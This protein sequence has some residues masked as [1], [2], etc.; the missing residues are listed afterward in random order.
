LFLCFHP[1]FLSVAAYSGIRCCMPLRTRPPFCSCRFINQERLC[2]P[3]F[4]ASFSL[5]FPFGSPL[6]FFLASGNQ[7]PCK[8]FSQRALFNRAQSFFSLLLE[9]TP[10]FTKRPIGG[11][12][13]FLLALQWFL[14]EQPQLGLLTSPFFRNPPLEVSPSL[15]SLPLSRSTESTGR[16]QMGE[17]LS[18]FPRSVH[19]TPPLCHTLLINSF[20][21]SPVPS[22]PLY[23]EQEV[24]F[25]HS[26]CSQRINNPLFTCGPFPPTP[27]FFWR[28][29]SFLLFGP[30]QRLSNKAAARPFAVSQHT[31]PDHHDTR[32]YFAPFRPP[33]GSYTMCRVTFFIA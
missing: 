8:F 3:F 13:D 9:T 14:E 18:R 30:F 29:D 25:L 22:P 32:L 24:P 4:L 28:F 7:G 31:L 15:R 33:R 19:I 11:L 20:F 12:K 16:A 6:S 5:N 2:N 23:I 26:I 27:I 21:F 1:K 17:R 10:P